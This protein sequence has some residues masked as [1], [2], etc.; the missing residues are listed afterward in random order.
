MADPV[1]SPSTRQDAPPAAPDAAEWKEI[2][3]NLEFFLL[4]EDAELVALPGEGDGKTDAPKGTTH[5]Q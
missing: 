2:R 5:G 1:A 4:M 3:A